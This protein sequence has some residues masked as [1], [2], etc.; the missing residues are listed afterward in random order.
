MHLFELIRET[1]S[2]IEMRFSQIVKTIPRII[3][4]MFRFNLVLWTKSKVAAS[5][6]YLNMQFSFDFILLKKVISMKLKQYRATIC[7]TMLVI[8]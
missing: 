3:Y 8:N 2:L 1:A 5:I 7:I 4:G 6:K